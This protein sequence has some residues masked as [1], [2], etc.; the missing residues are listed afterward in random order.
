MIKSP[1]QTLPNLCWRFIQQTFTRLGYLV[2]HHAEQRNYKDKKQSSSCPSILIEK[3]KGFVSCSFI[4][5]IYFYRPMSGSFS[6]SLFAPKRGA[7]FNF[8]L[9][10]DFYCSLPLLLFLAFKHSFLRVFC[11][12]I[13]NVLLPSNRNILQTP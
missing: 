12:S 8:F 10:Y 11:I 9:I 2:T 5:P 7:K 6:F 4:K 1:G 13:Y 3:L